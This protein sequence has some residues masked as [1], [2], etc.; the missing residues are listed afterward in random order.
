MAQRSPELLGSL[1]KEVSRSFYLTM[2]ILPGAVRPQISLAYLLARA[3]DTIADTEIVSLERRLDA[4]EDLRGRILGKNQHALNLGELAQQQGSASEKILLERVEEA[5]AM[6][7][8]FSGEDQ[9]RI[10]DVLDT[11]TG[12][13][14]LDLQRFGGANEK[15]IVALQTDAELDDYTYRVAGCVGEF[16]TKICVAH[17]F[18]NAAVDADFLLANGVRFGKGL[19]LVNILRDLPRD[20]RNG[21]CYIPGDQ[22]APLGLSPEDLLSPANEPKF[23]PLYE[24]YLNLAQE[25]LAAGWDYTNHLP[26]NH[27]RVRLACAWPILIGAKTLGKLR[28]EN[29][30]DPA[31]RVKICRGEVR[32]IIAKSLLFYPFSSAWSRQFTNIVA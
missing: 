15:Q 9:Q 22:L 29:V 19:Q 7:A 24:Q 2:R 5:V 32:E 23:R 10:R 27:S 26:R 31:Q 6:L 3:T 30:L 4:L 28:L 8:S 11:I 16:W 13:Q 1:L 17:L 20:L 14:A 12:G 21:R 25:H 18:Q